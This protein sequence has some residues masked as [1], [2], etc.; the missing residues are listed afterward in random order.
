MD[1]IT[2]EIRRF[3]IITLLEILAVAKGFVKHIEANI[4]LCKTM[5]DEV[6]IG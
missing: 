3:A 4:Q 5:V 2:S 6:V 1:A